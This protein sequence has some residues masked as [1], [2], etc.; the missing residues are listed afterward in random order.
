MAAAAGA[1]SGGVPGIAAGARGAGGQGAALADA[2]AW[3]GGVL[4]CPSSRDVSANRAIAC[5]AAPT[6]ADCLASGQYNGVEAGCGPLL[7]GFFNG[8]SS[9][10]ALVFDRE[11][12]TL[13]GGHYF[14]DAIMPCVTEAV[15]GDV[16][17]YE[18]S[19]WPMGQPPLL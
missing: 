1:S 18:E 5:D 11:R 17:T 2:C 13:V 9:G 15:F 19:G 3:E 10:R 6:L 12:G 4:T 14:S 16:S 7:S 8:T